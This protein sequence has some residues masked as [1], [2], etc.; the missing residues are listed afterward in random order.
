MKRWFHAPGLTTLATM[1][2]MATLA[3]VT[4][5]TAGAGVPDPVASY[6]NT[7][8]IHNDACPVGSNHV[9]WCPAGDLSLISAT[10]GVIDVGGNPCVNTTVMVNFRFTGEPTVTANNL[11]VC[12]TTN[13]M[14]TLFGVTDALGEVT[15]TFTGGGCGC[16]MMD[17]NAWVG[18]AFVCQTQAQFCV[19]SP[20]MNGNGTINF[21]DTFQ[22]LPQL[23]AGTGWCADFNCSNSVNF[24]DTFQYLPHLNGAHSCPGSVIPITPCP[25]GLC[26]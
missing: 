7:S 17:F 21:Q 22:Y 24:L 5:S 14:V 4:A 3:L 15:F 2:T 18:P 9:V 16:L 13:G 23:N 26:P 1:A 12:G 20:D 19:K 8:V 11:W 10:I 6:C 25:P